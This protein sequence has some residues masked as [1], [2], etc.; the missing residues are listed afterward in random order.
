MPIGIGFANTVN[1]GK[2]PVRFGAELHYTLI[3]PDHVLYTEWNFRFYVIPATG[4]HV[5]SGFSTIDL[6]GDDNE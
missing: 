1:I 3:K 2:I 5:N 6:T 4:L